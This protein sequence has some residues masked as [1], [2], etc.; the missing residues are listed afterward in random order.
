M[1]TFVHDRS[2]VHRKCARQSLFINQW[3]N[4]NILWLGV[5]D[6]PKLKKNPIRENFQ[7]VPYPLYRA[8]NRFDSFRLPATLIRYQRMRLN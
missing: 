2:P 6:L 8:A 5:L 4:A 3:A 7:S 1:F